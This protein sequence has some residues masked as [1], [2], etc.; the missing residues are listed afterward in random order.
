MYKYIC[1]YS[2]MRIRLIA[3]LELSTARI[4]KV[5]ERREFVNLRPS[6]LFFCIHFSLPFCTL[7]RREKPTFS[8]TYSALK[9]KRG[10]PVFIYRTKH[11]IQSAQKK[12]KKKKRR[13]MVMNS[14]RMIFFR[15]RSLYYEKLYTG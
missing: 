6:L 12:K 10:A 2:I 11:I 7:N 14:W 4:D 9:N 8:H 15:P 13:S 5:V 1:V 3:A